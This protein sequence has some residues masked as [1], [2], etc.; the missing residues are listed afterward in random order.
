MKTPHF[1][2][3]TCVIQMGENEFHS[4]TQT[5]LILTFYDLLIYKNQ[6]KLREGAAGDFTQSLEYCGDHVLGGACFPTGLISN[7]KTCPV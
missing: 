4:N 5:T 2:V 3:I 7:W 6:H 1:V